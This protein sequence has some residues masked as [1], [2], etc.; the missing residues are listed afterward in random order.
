MSFETCRFQ[1]F[2]VASQKK[3]QP[4]VLFSITYRTRKDMSVKSVQFTV[5]AHIMAALGYFHGE[6]VSSAELADSVNADPTFV[7]KSLSKLSKA[8]LVV[9]TRG[10]SGASVL[11]RPPRQITLLDIYRASAAPPAFAIHSYPVD[12]RCPVSCNIKGCMASVLSRAQ[13][14]FERSLAK[15]TL[16]NLVSQI[17]EKAH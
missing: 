10:K 14:S 5:A 15:I 13:Y 7:R 4:I 12:K 11:A 6:A 1:L 8:G 3:M 2:C 17:R 9:T 16:A